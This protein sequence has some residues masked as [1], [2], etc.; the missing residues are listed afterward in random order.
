MT[1]NA[2]SSSVRNSYRS[3]IASTFS[4][5]FLWGIIASIAPLSQAWPFISN[6][7]GSA[8]VMIVLAGPISSLFGN[9]LMGFLS[10]LLGRR[11]V[12]IITMSLY[13]VGAVVI[14]FAYSMVSLIVGIS[15]ATFG[16]A[17]EEI[18]TIALLAE[19]SLRERRGSIITNGMNFANIGSAFIAGLLIIVNLRNLGIFVQR[20]A[21]LIPALA[22]IGIIVYSRLHLPESYRW[23][24]SKG[25]NDEARAEAQ[26][27]GLKIKNTRTPNAPNARRVSTAL[28]YLVLAML[29]LSQYLTFGL[30]AYIVPYYEFTGIVVS[31]LVFFGLLGASVAGPLAGRLI[32]HGRKNYT[33][34]AFLGGF[35]TVVVILLE[36]NNLSN[37]FIFVPLLFI[38]MAFSEFA[39]ASRTTLEPELFP[40]PSRG[41]SIGFV[42]IV[43]M[44]A[45]PATIYLFANFTLFQEI[46]SNVILWGVGFAGALIW[47]FAG[48]ETRN[49]DLDFQLK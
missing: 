37:L 9:V 4:G 48:I 11:R 40:T 39:W 18:P 49:L 17:G 46:L 38:N 22:L 27:L 44:M 1:F 7:S 28:S 2:S 47:F 30:M 32:T 23:L 41:K 29:A 36:V 3:L 26:M 20:L 42:R 24:S 16:I 5:I 33:L 21:I 10:D 25:R 14:S 31:Y 15:L 19:D 13:F 43:P 6:L 12:F 8:R 34:F 35:M 45:Y